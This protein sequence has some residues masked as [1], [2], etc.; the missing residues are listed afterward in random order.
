MELLRAHHKALNR[1]DEAPVSIPTR[2]ASPAR[3]RLKLLCFAAVFPPPLAPFP[4]FRIHE[5]NL[6]KPRMKITAYNPHVGS[7]PR[8]LVLFSDN[9]DT[10]PGADLVMQSQRGPRKAAK[11]AKKDDL[12]HSIGSLFACGPSLELSMRIWPGGWRSATNPGLWTS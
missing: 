9:Q 4:S 10:P 11:G 12:R 5:R 8:T 1:G 6:L 3:R 7:F 2:T